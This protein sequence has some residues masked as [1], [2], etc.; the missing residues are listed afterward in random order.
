MSEVTK[1]EQAVAAEI[2][3]LEGYT[4]AIETMIWLAQWGESD[5]V[6]MEAAQNLLAHSAVPPTVDWGV[7]FDSED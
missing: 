1:L 3:P 6:R 7:E 4:V 5:A 2:N